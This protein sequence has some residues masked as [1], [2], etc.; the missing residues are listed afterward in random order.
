M[1]KVAKVSFYWIQFNINDFLEK[2]GKD[3]KG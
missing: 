3:Y 1:E 2:S